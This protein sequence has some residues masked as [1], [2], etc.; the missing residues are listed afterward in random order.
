MWNLTSCCKIL[1]RIFFKS[2]HLQL[3]DYKFL[4]PLPLT[5][6]PRLLSACITVETFQTIP[7][8]YCDEIFMKILY[9][10]VNEVGVTWSW[11]FYRHANKHSFYFCLFLFVFWDQYIS[12]SYFFMYIY[13]YDVCMHLLYCRF[14]KTFLVPFGLNWWWLIDNLAILGTFN[15]KEKGWVL[16]EGHCWGL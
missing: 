14:W 6:I 10:T 15:G 3:P 1:Q 9:G 12:R 11:H 13:M 2:L 8:V 4:S 16:P 5:V 7:Y